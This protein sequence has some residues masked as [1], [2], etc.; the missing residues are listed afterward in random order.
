MEVKEQNLEPD[1]PN[2]SRQDQTSAGLKR[3]P[4]LPTA[5]DL[6][7][8]ARVS[9]TYKNLRNIIEKTGFA[10]HFHTAARGVLSRKLL[11][12]CKLL[13]LLA[14]R[15]P[16]SPDEVE[17]VTSFIKR[18]NS[19][20][21][22]SNHESLTNYNSVHRATLLE[23]FGLR[24]Q[25][26][27]NRPP[28]QIFNLFPHYIS[29]E[30]NRLRIKTPIYLKILNDLPYTVAT[31]PKTGKPFVAVIEVPADRNPG[32]I[33]AVGDCAIFSDQYIDKDDNRQLVVNIIRWLTFQN[34]LDC[35]DVRISSVIRYGQTG[36]FSVVLH[37]PRSRRL[38]NLTCILESDAGALVKQ[39]RLEVRSIPGGGKTQLGWTVEPQQLGHQTLRLTIDFPQP[40][41]PKEEQTP[42]LFFE[43]VAQFQCVPDAD[44]DL[45]FL[46]S[47]GKAPE[48]VETEVPFEVQAVTRWAE[49]AKSVP[50]QL[51]LNCPLSHIKVE[52]IAAERWRLTALDA[53]D[54]LITLK[55]N[56]MNQCISRLVHAYPSAKA[57]IDTI[58][59]NIVTPLAAEIRHQVSQIRREFD[60]H[61]MQAIPFRLFT[62][63]EQVNQLYQHSQ[64]ELLLEALHAARDET[65]RF[66]PLVEKLLLFIAPTSSPV[67]G[68]CIPYDPQLAAHLAKEH[69]LYKEHLAYNFLCLEGDNRYG[70]IWLEGNI[71]ALL[72]H[73]KYGHGFFFTNT[74]IGRQL[75]ILYRHGLLRSVDRE[76]LKSSYSK[77]LHQEYERVIKTLQHSTLVINEGFATWMELTV[78][79]RLR[80]AISQT[81]YRRKDFLFNDEQLKIL[82]KDNDNDYFQRFEPFY[83]SRYQ[84]GYEYLEEIQEYFGSK[85]GSKCAVQAM[86]KAADVDLGI[87]E[88]GGQVKFGLS[89]AQMRSALLDE[90]AGDD[91]LTYVRLKRIR[92][93]LR[94]HAEEI[95]DAQKQLQ[96]HRECLHRECPVNRMISE[97]LGW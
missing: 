72:L 39:Q 87:T 40:N 20:L 62:P 63:E 1:N 44:I 89:A 77:F 37:N 32:R 19:V 41:E 18:G 17:A 94:D 73:E 26:L 5:K 69:P 83:A 66:F 52:P 47:E 59:E 33:V 78:L 57:Q 23:P 2:K 55:A 49:R 42:S 56:E 75:A 9:D 14:P 54:W 8:G 35:H 28:E 53:G 71:A 27:L 85:C 46:N 95:Q 90:Q 70:Q 67:Y 6:D 38:E 29:S 16:L 13:V 3:V 93:I 84:E 76:G 61:E 79:H 51:S 58:Q 34:P 12:E 65:Q 31:L 50:L 64:K 10:T 21:V 91:A 92:V 22:A 97:H 45:A 48:I 25:E 68:C 11:R 96:C 36:E 86:I 88:Q 60:T 15:Q 82:A 43:P 24:F 80:G 74:T 81:V 4:T 7:E 30:I